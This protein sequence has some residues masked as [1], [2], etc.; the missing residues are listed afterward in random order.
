MNPASWRGKRV[1]ITGHTGFK[2][3]WLSMLLS[4]FGARVAGYALDPP[5]QP[6]LFEL[7][8]VGELIDSNVGDVRDLDTLSGR[9]R[10][11]APEFIFH[12][13]AQSVVLQSY[14]DPVE[15]YSTNVLGTVNVLESVR[16]LRS[17]CTVISVTTDKCYENKGWIW[18]YR[19]I[20]ALGGRDPYSNSKACAELVGDAYRDS[21]FPLSRR[22]EHGVGL[23]S[24]RAGNVI[25]GGDWTARQLIPD[26]IAAFLKS[27]AVVLRHPQSVRPWQHVLDCLAG[28]LTLAE[29]LASDINAYSGGWNF[30]PAHADSRPVCYVV[31]KLAAHWGLKDAWVQDGVEHLPE[32]RLLRLDATKAA[33]SL[34]WQCQLPID[35]AL[36]WVAD[37]YRDFH[38]GQDAR[39][40]SN[41]QIRAYVETGT[42]ARGPERN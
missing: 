23:A 27:R 42:A 25:G 17:P 39:E 16:R 15:T 35:D 10:D 38:G 31:E 8:R 29:A 6:S 36:R 11:F 24:A 28:Y 32:E 4:S 40:L 22:G 30:G 12:M 21:F 18:G 13:A 1:L 7:A 19:E 3:A 26:T 41:A 14:E 5:T 37:W 34:G 33:T 2:G 20:D 9:V